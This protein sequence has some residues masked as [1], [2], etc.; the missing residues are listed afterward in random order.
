M[1]FLL[2]GFD[3][4]GKREVVNAIDV[5]DSEGYGCDSGGEGFCRDD[6]DVGSRPLRL[7]MRFSA[8]EREFC[9]RSLRIVHLHETTAWKVVCLGSPPA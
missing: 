8:S 6:S 4:L 2:D 3:E 5:S 1:S 9:A 7:R